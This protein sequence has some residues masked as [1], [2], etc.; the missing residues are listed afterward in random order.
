MCSQ[1]VNSEIPQYAHRGTTGV[2]EISRETAI[3]DVCQIP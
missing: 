1:G 2:L 3:V